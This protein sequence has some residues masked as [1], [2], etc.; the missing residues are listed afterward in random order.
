MAAT[1]NHITRYGFA[2]LVLERVAS[3]AGYTRG[4]LYHLFA[5]KEELVLAVVESGSKSWYEEVASRLASETD[6]VGTLIAAAR[7]TAVFSRH[8]A[9]KAL[10]R[11]RTEFAGTNHPIGKAIDEVL[12]SYAEDVARLVTAGRAASAIPPGPPAE[13]VAHA[14]IG[15]M[16]G[17]VNHLS[18][19]EPFD[20][21]F[22][23]RALLGVLGL[24][25]TSEK[26]NA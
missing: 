4:A 15:V 24:P 23:E 25:P 18:G 22:A 5:N 21:I 3:D 14:Y 13:M 20:A 9:A 10:M 6:P 26:E 2:D 1:A 7:D 19:Q 16:E 12:A 11:L 17:V 8:E